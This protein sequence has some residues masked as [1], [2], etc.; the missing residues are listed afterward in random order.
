MDDKEYNTLMFIEEKKDIGKYICGYQLNK[1][2]YEN[3]PKGIIRI[4]R[5]KN[6]FNIK[7]QK[8]ESYYGDIHLKLFIRKWKRVCI[9]N[10]RR[11]I[12]KNLAQLVLNRNKKIPNDIITNISNML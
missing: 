12:E 5:Y 1:N 7:N 3:A 10:K 2:N 11:N 6:N 9:T 8:S 4:A